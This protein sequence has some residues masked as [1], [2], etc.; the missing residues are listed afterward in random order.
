[1]PLNVGAIGTSLYRSAKR[2]FG[3]W[4]AAL[5]A[6]GIDYD[7]ILEESRRQSVARRK[8]TL[9]AKKR[10]RPKKKR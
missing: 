10:K 1:M 2:E 4:R 9:A 5:S 6:A 3:D 8:A 7:R